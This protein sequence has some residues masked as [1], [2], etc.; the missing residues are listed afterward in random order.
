[1]PQSAA[2]WRMEPPVS[3]P[4][5]AMASPAVRAA[6]LPPGEPPGTRARPHRLRVFRRGA[7]GEL[8]EVEAAPADGAGVFQLECDGGVVGRDEVRED[9]ARGRERLAGDGDHVFQADG[10]AVERA[11]GLAGG[12][13]GVGGA[14]LREGVVGVVRVEGEDAVVDGLGALDDGLREL[15]GGELF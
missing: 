12:A 2:G 13:A 1:M 14:G 3:E 9:L 10:D 5:V 7:H 4:S 15:D 6:G 8:V 11:A